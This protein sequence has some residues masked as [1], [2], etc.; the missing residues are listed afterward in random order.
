MCEFCSLCCVSA[1]CLRHSSA[2]LSWVSP[3]GPPQLRRKCPGRLQEAFST[4]SPPKPGASTIPHP[5][6]HPSPTTHLAARQAWSIPLS[7]FIWAPAS[8]SLPDTLK[9]CPPFAQK[10]TQA[11]FHGPPPP[12]KRKHP[13]RVA[14]TDPFGSGGE[15]SF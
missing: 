1:P 7:P 4:L 9:Q 13:S 12:G 10:E 11:G 14:L 3:A 15:Q 6:L 5:P 8:A 2:F